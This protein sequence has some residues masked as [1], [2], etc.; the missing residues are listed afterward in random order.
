MAR[1]ITREWTAYEVRLIGVKLADLRK[2]LRGSVGELEE[3]RKLWAAY[4]VD[5]RIP[6][7]FA[8][9]GE[10]PNWQEAIKKQHIELHKKHLE[11]KHNKT[12]KEKE[13]Q[14]LDQFK[15]QQAG[16]GQARGEERDECILCF[17]QGKRICIVPCGHMLLCA[18]CGDVQKSTNV[19][20]FSECPVCREAMCEPFVMDADEWEY[21]GGEVFDS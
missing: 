17:E 16:E 1:G 9:P 5:A 15:Q 11:Q 7:E 19:R 21:L 8:K 13:G 4:C 18:D 2:F 12:R 10:Q 6:V 14:L 3:E 20:L